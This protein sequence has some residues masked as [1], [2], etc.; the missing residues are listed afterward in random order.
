MSVLQFVS[1][2]S[3]YMVG[4]PLNVLVKKSI[5][6]RVISDQLHL[7]LLEVLDDLGDS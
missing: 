3:K 5:L 2:N 4:D 1:L 7:K 6:Q